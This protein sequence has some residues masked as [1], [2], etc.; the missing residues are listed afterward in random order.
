[1]R[2]R[3]GY[4]YAGDERVIRRFLLFPKEIKGEVR[5]LEW[6]SIRQQLNGRTTHD[7]PE[8]VDIAW[9]DDTPP[10]VA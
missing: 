3:I 4:C 7:G 9:V 10:E 5:W 1:M 8:W 2:W 6:A